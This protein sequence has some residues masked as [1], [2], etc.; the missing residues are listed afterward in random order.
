MAPSLRRARIFSS[1]PFMLS[2]MSSSTRS[3]S[4]SSSCSLSAK[5]SQWHLL[6]H[7][8]GGC[9]LGPRWRRLRRD[10]RRGPYLGRSHGWQPRLVVRRPHLLLG[11]PTELAGLC[12]TRLGMTTGVQPPRRGR[13]EGRGFPWTL[14]AAHPVA[15]TSAS[16]TLRRRRREVRVERARRALQLYAFDVR[17]KVSETNGRCERLFLSL[18]VRERAQHLVGAGSERTSS[19]S[20]CGRRLRPPPRRPFPPPLP[21]RSLVPRRLCSLVRRRPDRLTLWARCSTSRSLRTP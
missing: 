12:P 8:G 5:S 20:P 21:G 18:C 19:V 17:R 15:A 9:L 6:A 13:H 3:N 14:A 7:A 1:R 11:D 4:S 16:A 2:E 10:R